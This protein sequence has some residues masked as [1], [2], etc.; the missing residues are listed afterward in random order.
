MFHKT[1][2][3]K[4]GHLEQF[5]RDAEEPLDLDD[6][7]NEVVD[8]PASVTN[9]SASDSDVLEAEPEHKRAHDQQDADELEADEPGG[10]VADVQLDDVEDGLVERDADELEEEEPAPPLPDPR[11]LAPSSTGRVRRRPDRMNL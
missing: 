9:D 2:V 6:L 5:L 7:R 8:E 3:L 1:C 10:E 4:I 11:L